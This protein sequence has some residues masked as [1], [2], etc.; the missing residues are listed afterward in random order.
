MK[1][2]KVILINDE[3]AIAALAIREYMEKHGLHTAN[4]AT[5]SKEVILY[6][7]LCNEEITF[8]LEKK[9]YFNTNKKGGG[10]K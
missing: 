10:L 9:Q 4:G 7:K 6:N 5:L 2:L 8:E 3:V 1:Q